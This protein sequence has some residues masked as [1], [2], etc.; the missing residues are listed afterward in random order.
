MKFVKKFPEIVIAL[1]MVVMAVL[2]YAGGSSISNVLFHRGGSTTNEL[3][4]ISTP[5]QTGEPFTVEMDLNLGLAGTFELNVHPDDCVTGMTVNGVVFP[6]TNYPG[7]CSWNQGFTVGSDEFK[8]VLGPKSSGKYHV[9]FEMHNNSGLGGITAALSTH[10]VL[11]AILSVAFYALLGLLVFMVGARLRIDK[12]LLFCFF[13]GLLLRVGYTQNTFYDER[14]HDVGGHIAYIQTIAEKHHIPG[15]KECWSCYHPPVY[16]VLSAG[17]WSL[18]KFLNASPFSFVQWLDFIFSLVALGFGLACI[19]ALLYGNSRLIAGL[20]WS[21]WPS[22]LLASPRVGNDILLY[23]FYAV[24]LW[25]VLNYLKTSKGQFLI[26]AVVAATLAYWTKTS[27]AIAFAAIGV[28]VLVHFVPR[29]FTAKPRKLEWVS[30]GLLVVFGGWIA[31]LTLTNSVVANAAGNDN[32]VL[33]TNSPGNFLYFD[34]QKFLTNPYIDPWHDELGRQYFWN[35]LAKTSLFGEFTLLNTDAGKWFACLASFCFVI[36]VGFTMAGLWRKKW[37]R[38]DVVLVTQML[39]FFVSMIALRLKYPFS[40]SNDFRYIVPV[41][42][43]VLPFTA[44]G[45]CGDGA[46]VKRRVCGWTAVV[47]FAV[48]A[49]IVVL[50]A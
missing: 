17:S 28:A 7:Y 21:V 4:P 8:R 47:I 37:N 16:Y 34:L 41:L 2:Q 13:L 26:T 14:G 40:C 50:G 30:I 24:S 49:S 3:L 36:L 9:V 23:A 35:Y 1:A 15:D 12:R 45:I 42:L 44:E 5:M 43:S 48:S 27:G 31:F 20:L 18:A 11:P 39:A 22:F 33:V 19:K 6:H 38:V 32:T 10:G 25:G 46:S 29:V